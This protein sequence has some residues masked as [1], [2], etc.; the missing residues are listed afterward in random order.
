MRVSAEEN[1][2]IDLIDTVC[3]NMTEWNLYHVV[4]IHK[5]EIKFLKK[6]L[7]GEEESKTRQ[8]SRKRYENLPKGKK[9]KSN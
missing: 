7:S 3:N 6:K 1:D 5:N 9:T 4:F 2:G 8:Y